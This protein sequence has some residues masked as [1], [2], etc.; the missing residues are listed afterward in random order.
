MGIG[1]APNGDVWIA[2]GSDNQLLYFPK[3][4]I[5]AGRIVKPAGLVSPF[6]VVI[7]DE[8]RVWVANSSSDTVVRFPADDPSK[9]ETFRCGIGVRALAL[10]SKGNVWVANN[11]D[12]KTPVPKIPANASIMEQ[13]KLVTDAMFKYIMT[14]PG[15]ITGQVNMIRPD[16]TQPVPKASPVL[17]KAF[18]GASMWTAMMTSGSAICGVVPPCCWP[19]TTPPVIRPE[20]KPE[21]PSTFSRAAAS[22]W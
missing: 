11:M 22:R 13:F 10:D 6:D 14:P 16:G 8:N 9:A 17:A 4:E 7:D 1:V 15:H 21:T 19:G 3:G 20:R 2:D 5:K 18:R 12:L